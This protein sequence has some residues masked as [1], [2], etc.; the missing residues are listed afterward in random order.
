MQDDD[1]NEDPSKGSGWFQSRGLAPLRRANR[2][3]LADGIISSS[4]TANNIYFM[5]IRKIIGD[6]SEKTAAASKEGQS[7][8]GS[9][10]CLS[11]SY[12]SRVCVSGAMEEGLVLL[13]K[14]SVFSGIVTD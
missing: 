14:Q 11:E 7:L 3:L 12:D 6:I 8:F 4:T 10:A 5:E 13:L 1:N 9:A 2:R